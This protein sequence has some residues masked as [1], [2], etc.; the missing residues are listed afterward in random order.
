MASSEAQ[1]R[2]SNS[3]MQER[4]DKMA[5]DREENLLHH[6]E[7]VKQLKGDWTNASRLGSLMLCR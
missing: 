3:D 7:E 2:S 5:A 6:Q 1:V 4:L